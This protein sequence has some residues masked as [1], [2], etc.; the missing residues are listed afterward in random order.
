MIVAIGAVNVILEELIF[1]S[2]KLNSLNSVINTERNMVYPDLFRFFD[3]NSV[4]ECG[5][6][7]IKMTGCFINNVGNGFI[8]IVDEKK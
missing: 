2:L 1:C 8:I 3:C 5:S 7:R 4:D 6:I